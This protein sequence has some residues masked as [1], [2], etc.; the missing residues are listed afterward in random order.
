MNDLKRAL[1][2]IVYTNKAFVRNP[3]SAFFTLVFPL[4]FLVIFSVIFGSGKVRVGPGVIVG[5]ATFYVPSIAAFSVITA[6]YTNIAISLSFARD[7]GA[8]KRIRGSPLPVWAYL[9]ARITHA[10]LI[11]VLLVAICA[12]FGAI[13]YGATLPTQTLPAFLLTLV[14]GA[15]AF[16]ALGVAVTALIPNSDAA[17]AIVN[18]SVLPLLFISNVFIPL[19]NPPA[20]LDFVSK[21]FPIRHFADSLVGSF[22][23]LSGSGLQ[24][25]DLIVVGVWGLA[26]VVV[27][28]RF[29]DWEPRT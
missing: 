4:M 15:A 5:V 14:V 8:L 10:V 11:A 9:F 2:Q 27:A 17:P 20:W 12:A 19:Q 16:C 23:Q 1:M 24:T 29:F 26:A 6:C 18:A 28:A 3:A 25:S 22:F 21:I 7:T 13:F